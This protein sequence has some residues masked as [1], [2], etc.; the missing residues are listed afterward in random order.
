M[1]LVRNS[2][3]IRVP[4]A[5]LFFGCNGR[6]LRQLS[7]L[8]TTLTVDAGSTLTPEGELGQEFFVVAD[9]EAV[10]SVRGT[11]K[12]RF[13]RGHFF[14]EMAL[15]DGGPRTATV[16]AET[17]MNLWVYSAT[18]FQAMLDCSPAIRHRLLVEMARRL[19]RADAAA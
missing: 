7:R 1:P 19:R 10:C 4:D 6:E 15:L 5:P 12:A 17:P 3:P 13:N 2:E 8:G 14:G 16:T 18:E 11:S 9:G